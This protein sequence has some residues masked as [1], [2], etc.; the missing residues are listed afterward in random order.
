MDFRAPEPPRRQEPVLPMVNLVFLLLVFFLMVA[1]LAPPA[2]V[3]VEPPRVA[4]AEAADGRGARLHLDAQGVPHFEAA[5]GE[6]A[7][8]AARA[9]AAEGPL[10]LRADRR[11]PGHALAAALA[12]LGPAQVI[13][14]V[15]PEPEA[16]PP[17]SP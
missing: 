10:V 8:A 4:G 15:E 1:T 13:L 7:L 9:A 5:T 17:A 16:L 3:P 6:A 11:A 12:A 14:L 2:P